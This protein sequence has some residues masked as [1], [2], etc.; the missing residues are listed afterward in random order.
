ML[1]KR[2]GPSWNDKTR[3]V[4]AERLSVTATPQFFSASE[5]QLVQAI[6]AR[7][8]PQPSSRPPIPVAALVDR[9]LHADIADGYRTDGMPHH[10]E[11]W[12]RGLGALEAEALAAF[13]R[14]FA[15]LSEAMQDQLLQR[16]EAGELK[17]ADWGDMPCEDFF[18]RR[19]LRDVVLAYY[20]HPTAWSEIGWGGPASPRGYVRLDF[21]ER[22]PWE[23]AEAKPGREAE[24]A[25]I[26]RHVR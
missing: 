5:F 8:V 1:A 3:E 2:N 7:I 20:A 9:K 24:A 10:R 6:A 22:D 14:P 15:E 19:V 26:N 23:S 17:A 16:A 12:R 18:K 21:N 11:A 13:H 25:R 4:I